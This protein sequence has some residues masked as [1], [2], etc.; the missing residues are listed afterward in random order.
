MNIT[1]IGLVGSICILWWE[2]TVLHA[3]VIALVLAIAVLF[4]VTIVFLADK[5]VG[6]LVRNVGGNLGKGM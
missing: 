1:A 2:P 6:A 5:F 3:M 4:N